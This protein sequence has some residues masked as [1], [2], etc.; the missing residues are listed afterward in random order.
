MEDHSG[1]AGDTG[2]ALPTVAAGHTTATADSTR[3]GTDSTSESNWRRVEPAKAETA[4]SWTVGVLGAVAMIVV[5]RG[6]MAASPDSV[7]YVSAAQSLLD[8]GGFAT[9]LEDPLATFPPLWSLTMAAIGFLGIGVENAAVVLMTA[10]VAVVPPLTLAVLRRTTGDSTARIIGVVAVGLTPVLLPW[11]F[12]ALSEVPFTAVLLGTIA[13]ALLGDPSTDP[14][15]VNTPT[16]PVVVSRRWLW[17]AVALGSTAPLIRYAG[18]AVPLALSLWVFSDRRRSDRVRL[19]LLTLVAGLAPIA[20]DLGINVA[21]TDAAFGERLPSSLNP[22]QVLQQG[23]TAVGRTALWTLDSTPAVIGLLLGVGLVC[24]VVWMMLRPGHSEPKGGRQARL[25]VGMAAGMQFAVTVA[26]RARSE[27]NDLDGRLLA[28]TAVTVLILAASLIGD[29]RL[30][31]T[32]WVR[33]L[34]FGFGALWCVVGVLALGRSTVNALA[35]NGYTS[36]AFVRA[37]SLPELSQIPE[38]C[39]VL[40]VNDLDNNLG[41]G[42]CGVLANEPWLWYRSD[43]RP[44]ITPRHGDREA[45]DI[46]RL[47]DAIDSGARVWIAWTTVNE[48]YGYLLDIDELREHFDLTLLGSDEGVELFSVAPSN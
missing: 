19:G 18:I 45:E 7:T 14:L 26:A 36:D 25:L 2:A 46:K 1:V 24:V 22:I 44:L 48:P 29:L 47:S 21:T 42:S 16:G 15:G 34:A 8:G 37:R 28:P 38:G 11:S 3:T 31:P 30:S 43:M 6:R 5:T 20:V 33:R 4:V 13:L 40:S 10:A 17:A 32:L 9:W 23:T 35:G 12:Q 41:S 39:R 27:I